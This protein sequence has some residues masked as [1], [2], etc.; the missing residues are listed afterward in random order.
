MHIGELLPVGGPE[1][2]VLRDARIRQVLVLVEKLDIVGEPFAE[3]FLKFPADPDD[4]FDHLPVLFRTQERVQAEA[5]HIREQAG[6]VQY[7]DDVVQGRQAV[8]RRPIALGGS[9][10]G[11]E[12]VLGHAPLEDEGILGH[13]ADV[14]NDVLPGQVRHLFVAQ[15]D[16]TLAVVVELADAQRERALAAPRKTHQG[17][18]LTGLQGQ[19]DVIQEPDPAFGHEG[20]ILDVEAGF[21]LEGFSAGGFQA[22]F[23]LGIE[24]FHGPGVADHTVLV[25]LIKLDEFLPGVVE[26]FLGRQE[27]HQGAQ[28]ELPFDGQVAAQDEHQEGP[29]AGK[30]VVGGFHPKAVQAPGHP[31]FLQPLHH[32][33]ELARFDPVGAIAVDFVDAADGLGDPAG[34]DARLVDARLVGD[35]G[36]FLQERDQEHGGR[37][38]AER[39]RGQERVQPEQETGEGEQGQNIAHGRRHGHARRS[40]MEPPVRSRWH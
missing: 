26:F 27:R 28:F 10:A 35:V 32:L 33:V 8:P 31:D 7:R 30:Q 19:V 9:L 13:D 23:R 5:Q 36:P 21:E 38:D 29:Q 3:F 25:D 12:Q 2:Q 34:K 16:V 37:V 24:E 40:W 18:V 4:G 14:G 39:D 11:V 15:Q 17:Q 22:M 6:L 1:G 20:E